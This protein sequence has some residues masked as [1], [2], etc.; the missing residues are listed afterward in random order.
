MDEIDMQIEEFQKKPQFDYRKLEPNLTDEERKKYI[1]NGGTFNF[2]A[3]EKDTGKIQTISE[4]GD[5]ELNRSFKR[6]MVGFVAFIV[7]AVF[8]FAVRAV[9]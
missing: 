9:L 5:E 1:T 4:K 8:T 7:I 6:F 3:Y 2:L